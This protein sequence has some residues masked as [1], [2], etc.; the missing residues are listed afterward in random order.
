MCSK[1]TPLAN[2]R[3]CDTCFRAVNFR[4]RDARTIHHQCEAIRFRAVNFRE[5]D[6]RSTF[7]YTGARSGSPQ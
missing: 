4:E 7:D 1:S 5:R 6:A 2:L 3:E